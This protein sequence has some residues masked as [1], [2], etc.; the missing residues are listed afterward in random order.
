MKT[1]ANTKTFKVK[2]FRIRKLIPK[3][4]FLC[5]LFQPVVYKPL[6]NC[7]GTSERNSD[8]KFMFLREETKPD[9]RYIHSAASFLLL[10][11]LVVQIWQT[12]RKTFFV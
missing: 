9:Y 4:L 5:S 11:S 12:V 1:G 2:A 7:I 3:F 10:F 6:E 8:K